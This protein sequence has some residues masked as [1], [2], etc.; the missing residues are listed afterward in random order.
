MATFNLGQAAYV[1]KGAYNSGTQYAPL[2]TVYYF[3]G[4]WVA[5]QAV[6]GVA[7]GSDNTK[8][9]CI[10]QGVK[11]LTVAAG[12]T[13]YANITIVLTD[14]T[15][16]T[17]SVPIGA[18][19]AGTITT[20]MLASSFMLPTSQG[21]TGTSKGAQAP[22]QTFLGTLTSGGWNSSALTQAL[23]ISGFTSSN[24]FIAKPNTKAGWIAAQDANIYPPTPGSGTLAFECETIPDADI[25]VTVYWW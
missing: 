6:T 16:S 18:I 12:N 8:W 17:T 24:A 3:G 22:I 1:N 7:P 20:S 25:P 14:G 5:L 4:T 19:G 10:T 9:L 11:S 15:S 23:S 2:N 13:G 21:G